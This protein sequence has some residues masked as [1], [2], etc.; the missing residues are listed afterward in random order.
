MQLSKFGLVLV[1][2]RSDGF[3]TGAP[4]W[5]ANL[6]GACEVEGGSL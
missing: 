2:A 3:L 1:A 5:I 6:R 4:F